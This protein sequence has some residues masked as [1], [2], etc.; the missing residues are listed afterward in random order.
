[1]HE[2]AGEE[3]ANKNYDDGHVDLLSRRMQVAEIPKVRRT[4]ISLQKNT[5]NK[6]GEMQHAESRG[7]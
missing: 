2:K 3:A 6:F 1:M 5:K 4:A 7:V